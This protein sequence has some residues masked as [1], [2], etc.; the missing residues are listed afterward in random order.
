LFRQGLPVKRKVLFTATFIS[1]LFCSWV[2]G[3]WL[4]DAGMANP[5][6]Y[7]Q[8]QEEVSPPSDVIPPA[9]TISSPKNNTEYGV[10]NVSLTFNLHVVVPTIP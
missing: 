3:T 5:Y 8:E 6:F 2:V 1:I 9:I 4:L 10:N 7:V